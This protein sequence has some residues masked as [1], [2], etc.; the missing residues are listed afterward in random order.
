MLKLGLESGDQQVLN[1]MN[2]GTDLAVASKTLNALK[3]A[4]ILTYVYLL[5]GTSFEDESAAYKTLKFINEHKHLIDYLN[6]AVFNLPRFSE[7]ARDLDTQEFYDGDL[8]LYLNFN[9]PRK[10]DRKRVKQF[11]DKIFKKQVFNQSTIKRNPPFFS[12]N[13]AMFIG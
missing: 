10:W 2:K 4:K 13:H 11:L 12:S 9:H 8:S 3:E 7:D 1:K 6:L 5:F